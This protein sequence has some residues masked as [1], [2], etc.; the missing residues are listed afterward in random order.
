MTN[1]LPAAVAVIGAG[2]MGNGI[3]QV[4]ASCGVTTHLL[5]IKQEYVD[6]GIANVHKSLA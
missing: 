2:T 1:S 4:F 6:K 5:D 3:A